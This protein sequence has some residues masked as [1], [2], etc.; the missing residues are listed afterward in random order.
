MAS[1][2]NLEV[3]IIARIEK[4]EASLAKVESQIGKTQAKVG[5]I[6]DDQKG[7]GKLVK[8]AGKAV[9]AF[10]AIE[11]GAKVAATGGQALLGIM[12][13]FAGESEDAAAHFEGAL[14]SAKQL[15]FGI[16]GA[17]D[18][19]HTLS[20]AIAG[21]DEQLRNLAELEK[22]V[23]DFDEARK[24]AA[25]QHATMRETYESTLR[26]V[27]I[28]ST[29]SEAEKARVV[30]QQNLAVE[31]E[32]VESQVAKATENVGKYI[33]GVLAM[34]ETAAATIRSNGEKTVAA[35]K[36]EAVLRERIA[37]EI[38][39][40]ARQQETSLV[41]QESRNRLLQMGDAIERKRLR[42]DA[43][44]LAI[45]EQRIR[46]RE[47]EHDFAVKILAAEEAGK[48]HVVKALK[49]AEKLAMHQLAGLEATENR[50]RAEDAA[51][52]AAEKAAKNAL[53]AAKERE[54]AEEKA[55]KTSEDFMKAKLKIEKEIA[56]AREEANKAVQGATSTFSTAGGSF[57]SAISA[58]VNEAKILQKISEQSR[59]FLAQIVKN[60]ANFAGG[61]MG[62]FA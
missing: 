35:L 22:G 48:D 36:E 59:D 9:A 10:A 40:Q 11:I 24:N 27:K 41:Y 31:I 44:A 53:E 21:V 57:T 62:G 26:Q 50:A 45:L 49:T 20:L 16:G 30:I 14:N 23:L 51:A 15:P 33:G 6:A 3:E 28:L 39:E 52:L 55:R 42:N 47:M 25:Q 43:D 4:F 5:E 1:E 61:F 38:E 56:K 8:T 7:M 19:I 60:T 2:F 13:A 17:I 37:R 34:T 58:Q 32:K 18:A 12:D 46:R 29:A 54:K